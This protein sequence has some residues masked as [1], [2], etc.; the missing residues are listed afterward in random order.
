MPAFH[1][2]YYPRAR[3]DLE[4]LRDDRE[5][6]RLIDAIFDALAANPF[7]RPPAKKRI[8]GIST[9]LFRLRVDTAKDSYRVFYVFRGSVVTVLR[10]VKKKD[11]DKIIRSFR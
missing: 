11:A 9:P 7:P 1:V 4:K 3:K 8:Q 2:E 5:A 6:V 10:I